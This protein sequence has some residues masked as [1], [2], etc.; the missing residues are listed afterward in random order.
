MKKKFLIALTIILVLCISC[1]LFACNDSNPSADSREK[2]IENFQN[3]YLKACSDNWSL[4]LS[5]EE[6]KELYNEGHYVYQKEWA[7]FYA[8]VLKSSTI[9][10][11]KI[12]ALNEQ[13]LYNEDLK[14]LIRE[15]RLNYKN[16]SD[17]FSDTGL[18]AE[19]ISELVLLATDRLINKGYATASSI[20]E[21]T[22]ALYDRAA[23]SVQTT[24][25]KLN[26][27]KEVKTEAEYLLES[28][29]D[30]E[31]NK[32][33]LNDDLNL[34]KQPLGYVIN[35]SYSMVDTFN[36]L[37]QFDTSSG[38]TDSQAQEAAVLLSGVFISVEELGD[39]FDDETVISVSNAVSNISALF[40]NIFIE[41][42]SIISFIN[43]VFI[44]A[45]FGLDYLPLACDIVSSMGRVI[46]EQMV[47]DY[48]SVKDYPKA[49][50]GLFLG[51]FFSSVLDKISGDILLERLK[52]I[53]VS[54]SDNLEKLAVA[55][56]I[57]ISLVGVSGNSILPDD[58][59]YVLSS[60]TEKMLGS[61]VS[62]ALIKKS[63]L[64]KV[65]AFK[66]KYAAN[67]DVSVDT[68]MSAIT[69]AKNIK[70]YLDD[71]VLNPYGVT[72]SID[73]SLLEDVTQ[74]PRAEC[75]ERW[76]DAII[77]AVDEMFGNIADDI[78]DR[79]FDIANMLLNDFISN[80]EL[81][82]ALA[83]MYEQYGLISE[84][85]EAYSELLRLIEESNI[86]KLIDAIK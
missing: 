80:D 20:L 73:L 43:N 34:I 46:D 40:G 1:A 70:A 74:N 67:N 44:Y 18:I 52:A 9:R 39:R 65:Y 23:Q 79:I 62:F 63:Q 26:E 7:A 33:S 11:Q 14:K 51:K 30:I 45:N 53:K 54:V 28:F 37:A 78:S 58:F 71:S 47:M 75:V 69:W 83:D 64:S 12:T 61:L 25:N 49:N 31:E 10:T 24:A 77:E 16:L 42:D 2:A 82:H 59:S 81:Y 50:Y 41:N 48:F 15:G 84:D 22:T 36:G 4:N 19:D 27:L 38:L 60:D 13:L 17:L 66:N 76:F 21:K 32:S 55:G 85:S 57:V 6:Q 5:A 56:S 72:I 68:I 3:A 35:F 29:E 8:D 86:D